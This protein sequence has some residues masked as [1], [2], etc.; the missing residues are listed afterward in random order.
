MTCPHGPHLIM[1][2]TSSAV[3]LVIKNQ[4]HVISFKN[5]KLLTH[6]KLITKPEYQQWMARAENSILSQLYSMCLTTGGVI[7][8]ECLRQ[9]QTYLS[10]LL[11]DSVRELPIG[12][13]RTKQ[14]PK[15]QEGAIITIERL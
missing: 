3:R 2:T 1:P 8:L 10:G 14:V 11:D 7:Q 5:S 6:G 13:W 15:G 12:N 9:L 4:G